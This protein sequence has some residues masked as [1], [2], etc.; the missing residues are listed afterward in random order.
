MD[1]ICT[2]HVESQRVCCISM[3]RTYETL[4]PPP[5]DAQ[6]TQH[7]HAQV[8]SDMFQIHVTD[9][10][11]KPQ[12]LNRVDR[13]DTQP[14]KHGLKSKIYLV[15]EW[16]EKAREQIQGMDGVEGMDTTVTSPATSPATSPVVRVLDAQSSPAKPEGRASPTSIAERNSQLKGILARASIVVEPRSVWLVYPADVKETN[17]AFVTKLRKIQAVARG[18]QPAAVGRRP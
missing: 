4:L 10:H 17:D 5:I 6:N 12:D 7:T 16:A 14:V 8:T 9:Q 15:V 2:P 11:G 1:R 18:T 13:N 3:T